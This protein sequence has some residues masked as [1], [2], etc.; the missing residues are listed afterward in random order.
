VAAAGAVHCAAGTA[1][2]ED[3][4]TARDPDPAAPERAAG[5][6]RP[7][8]LVNGLARLAVLGGVFAVVGLGYLLQRC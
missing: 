7:F 4:V 2:A 5:A 8:L 3:D 6:K 1:P